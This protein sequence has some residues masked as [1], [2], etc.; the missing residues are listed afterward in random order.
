MKRYFYMIL[1]FLAVTTVSCSTDSVDA[2]PSSLTIEVEPSWDATRGITSASQTVTAYVKLN[3]QTINWQVSSDSE[4]LKVDSGEVH[5]GSDE[6]EMVV[7][8]NDD[9]DK[10]NA[11]LTIT[12]G[13]YTQRLEVDQAG[14][15]FIMSD[16][17]RIVSA[18]ESVSFDVEVRTTSD[19]N[20]ETPEWIEAEKVGDPTVD[21]NGQTITLMRVSVDANTDAQARY[22]AVQLVP[23]EGYNAE[24]TVFQFGTD[25]PVTDDGKIDVAAEGNMSFDV[26]APFGIV[27]NVEA[28]YWVQCTQ[29]PTEDGLH[30]NYNFWIGKN[31]SDT[32]TGR[33]CVVKFDVRENDT[34]V[35]LPTISQD[36]VPAGGI[37]TGPGFKMFAE[38]YNAGEDISY[39]TS[40]SSGQT[41]I[42][43]LSDVN[44]S[45]VETWTPVG[46]ATRPFEGVF[47]GNGW[48]ITAWNGDN[49]LFGYIGENGRVQD[50]IVEKDCTMTFSG[51]HAAE[52][53]NG[54]L[55]GVLRGTL[56]NCE[57]RAAVAVTGLDATAETA[58]SGMVGLLDGGSI[59]NCRNEAAITVEEDAVSTANVYVGGIVG[60]TTGDGSSVVSCSHNASL[61]CYARVTDGSSLYVGGIAGVAAGTVTDCSTGEKLMSVSTDAS[62]NVYCGGLLGY[63]TANVDAC[64]NAQS[65]SNTLYRSGD[66]VYIEYTGGV[67]G[68]QASGNIKGCTNRGSIISTSNQQYLYMGGIAG[69]F[70]EGEAENNVNVAK[71]DL[72]GDVTAAIKGVRYATVGGLYGSFG[73]SQG[74]SDTDSSNSGPITITNIETAVDNSTQLQLGGIFGFLNSDSPVKS[75]TNTGAITANLVANFDT[76]S[77]GGIVGATECGVSGSTNEGALMI[78]NVVLLKNAS[79]K[80]YYGG[81]AGLNKL[82]AL[83]EYTDCVNNGEIGVSTNSTDYNLLPSF[84]GGILG[85]TEQP[86]SVKGCENNGYVNNSGANNKYDA[87]FSSVG[88]IVG[89]IYETSA[90]VSNCNVA[91]NTRNYAYNRT[92]DMENPA[93]MCHCGGIV[94][95]AVGES[96]TA[97]VSI[98][99]CTT[100]G[101]AENKRSTAAGIVGFAKYASISDCR[102]EGSIV[103]S[104]PHFSGGIAGCLSES[105]V[106][107]CVVKSP[108][109]YSHSGYGMDNVNYFGAAGIAGYMY[110]TSTISD[111][112][113]FATL[114]QNTISTATESQHLGMGIIAGITVPTSTVRDCGLGGSLNTGASG[115]ASTL[116][117]TVN[118]ENFESCIAGDEHAQTSGCYYWNG[119]E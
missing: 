113:A 45:E 76:F 18:D 22:G 53:W 97:R 55:A 56:D 65:I 101:N 40:E 63:S 61:T 89:A 13:L 83:N 93:R 35:T 117:M 15:V 3:V 31:L 47:R 39:W 95:C 52:S 75:L 90:E 59:S 85:Y 41:V 68:Y 8:A 118:S 44:M 111:C 70:A 73:A 26:K 98:S 33:E 116:I 84:V 66:A 71:M 23:P 11:V 51:S 77:V 69:M 34:E 46:T 19:W 87:L 88:G 7:D 79:S 91:A 54:V 72:Q 16:I 102:F 100:K 80:I 38:A 49:P 2:D 82:G 17:Y 60:K 14:N 1:A 67:A 50:I 29:T 92:V 81:I 99:D 106:T 104:G 4:W 24:F 32:K 42:N 58:F 94:G 20:I 62:R 57:N 48:L 36:F 43:V 78:N 107:G 30:M 105:E 103:G 108:D 64:V 9:F 112:K 25:V 109:L 6:L 96:S 114:I 21:D 10:R 110:G 27:E 115:N 74:S 5:T 37:V 119:Q 12:A 28:P 86:V